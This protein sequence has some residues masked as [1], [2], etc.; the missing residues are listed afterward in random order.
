MIKEHCSN[1]GIA[2]ILICLIACL[3]CVIDARCGNK[4]SYS[5]SDSIVRPGEIMFVGNRMSNEKGDRNDIS[6]DLISSEP[7][8]VYKVEWINCDTVRKP[9]EPFSLIAKADDMDGKP[10]VWHI[11]LEFPYSMVMGRYDVLN[12]YTDK[13]TISR[14]TS[15][16]GRYE[17][18]I[19]DIRKNHMEY[20]EDSERTKRYIWIFGIGLLVIVLSVASAIFIRM[21]RRLANRRKDM[22]ELSQMI[23]ERSEINLELREK[24]NALYKSRLDTLNML[25]NG[26]FD[27]GESDN[28]KEIFYKDVEKQIL[29]MRDGKSVAALEEIVNKYMDNTMARLKEQIPDLSI[30][31]LKFLTYIYSGFSPRAVCIFMNIKTKTFYNRRNLLKE[32]I[33]ASDAPD[34]D[35]FVSLMFR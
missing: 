31:E 29:A 7:F 2:R 35:Y 18:E 26:Y 19:I 25:C 34:R 13:G 8:T 1:C 9:L 4:I 27:S 28:M 15:D 33:L 21:R 12:I 20:V 22:E 14:F 23:E 30:N 3:L 16:N 6:F 17:Q 11:D 32:R 10:V 5:L 24:V